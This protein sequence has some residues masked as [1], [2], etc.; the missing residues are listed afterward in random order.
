MTSQ[1][2]SEVSETA[3]NAFIFGF[4]L[5]LMDVTRAVL[6]NTPR[7]TDK[8]AP[9]NQFGHLR[10]FPDADFRDVV[11]PNADTLYSSAW[12]DL[13]REPVVLT[14]PDSGGR[15]YLLPM[16][17]AFTEV[18]AAPGTRTTGNGP[19]AFAITGPRF[20]GVIAD[21][22]TR[23]AAPTALVWIIGRTQTDGPA[24]FARV[25]EFQDGLSLAPLSAWG[26]DY[27]PPDRVAVEPGVDVDTPPVT[28]VAQLTG[29]EFFTRLARLLTANPPADADAPVMAL[30]E[31]LGL[32]PGAFE[33]MPA[34]ATDIET[35]ARRGLDRLVTSAKQPISLSP[36]GWQQ[37][38]G[39][40]RYGTSYGMRALIALVGLGANLDADALYPHATVDGDG[41]A[42]NGA[43]D[44]RL[45]FAAGQTPP[46][47][48]FWSLTMYDDQQYFCANPIDRFAIGDRDD[49]AVNDDGS[50]DI[51]IS[52]SSP[53]IG[54]ESNWL[55]APPGPFNVFLRVYRPE[56]RM[57]AGEWRPPPIV[58]ER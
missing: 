30:F 36:E 47:G 23:I 52:H 39:L 43:H 22:L 14:V 12:L 17:S 50:I 41:H 34:L 35:G 24:D 37:L 49:L 10:A 3:A 38:R 48:A 21:G 16:L 19:G 33:P 20:D 13:E 32:R 2:A 44:Y 58:R 4:P 8:Q 56:Q 27:R 31:S 28:Q 42:L 55:P 1:A 45:R 54:R 11:S 46:A 7:P 26:A 57:L 29:A 25:H 18:F 40:G 5:V 9:M 53:G 6:T 15:Y 51:W